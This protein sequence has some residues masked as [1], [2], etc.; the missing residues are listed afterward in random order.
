MSHLLCSGGTEGCRLWSGVRSLLSSLTLLAL[1]IGAGMFTGWLADESRITALVLI[2]E[3]VLD[4]CGVLLAYA[5]WARRYRYPAATLLAGTMCSFLAVRLPWP[6]PG[7]QEAEFPPRWADNVQ[8][9]LPAIP[10]P[11]ERFQVLQW[12]V[13]AT[14]PPAAVISVAVATRPEVVVLSGTTDR[15]I[16]DRLVE[17]LGGEYQ[18]DPPEGEEM[19]GRL[20]FTRGAFNIC[21]RE[22]DSEDVWTH[23]HTAL[24][25]VHFSQESV[26]PL[27]T[28]TQ[29]GAWS[30]ERW[31]D[32]RTGWHR[33]QQLAA[34]LYS[35]SMLVIVDAPVLPTWRHTNSAM[36]RIKLFP[37][38]SVPNW[39]MRL[40]PLPMLPL[41]PLDRLWVG[42]ALRVQSTRRLPA[43][44]DRA[45]L[46]HVVEP[47]RATAGISPLTAPG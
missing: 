15:E 41:H 11:K 23:E 35:P 27:F 6:P 31:E 10:P 44:T 47:E 28:T 37:A 36:Q 13:D 2:W 20:V 45:P 18:I 14:T 8:T 17:E 21:G 43:D 34:L 30:R 42:S 26:V 19:P 5:L 24:R 25:F 16:G 40:G 33:A 39:P 3:P 46:L 4:L 22:V 7:D 32:T 29:P 1:L 38:P 9:C 12:T